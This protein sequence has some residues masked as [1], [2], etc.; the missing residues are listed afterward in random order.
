MS[1]KL[2]FPEDFLWGS[3]QSAYQVEGN[4]YN[5]EIYPQGTSSHAKPAKTQLIIDFR[6]AICDLGQHI[7][8]SWN[9]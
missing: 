9:V 3:A 5:N 2:V 6:V 8:R 7:Y 1:E 4:N